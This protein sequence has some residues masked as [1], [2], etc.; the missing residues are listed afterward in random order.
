M[1]DVD[2]EMNASTIVC[3]PLCSVI[4]RLVV[5]QRAKDAALA[6]GG[7]GVVWRCWYAPAQHC[8]WPAGQRQCLW[9][10]VVQPA[11]KANGTLNARHDPRDGLTT[12]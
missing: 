10:T 11:R 6:G 7:V 1:G 2:G 9:P 5:A 8:L 4:S 3:N 12:C